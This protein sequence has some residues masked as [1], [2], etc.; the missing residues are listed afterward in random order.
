MSKK[1]KIIIAVIAAVLL[2]TIGGATA[3]LAQDEEPAP[4]ANCGNGFLARVAQILNVPEEDLINAFR[5]AREEVRQECQAR[6]EEHVERCW[7]RCQERCL[8]ALDKAVEN[9]IIT[10]DEA[11]QIKEWW[12]QR[13]EAVDKLGNY[14]FGARSALKWNK[15]WQNRCWRGNGP[16][17]VEPDED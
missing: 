2:L 1:M 6:Y 10:E 15:M 17:P 16:S 13:P 4:P 8:Q 3:V 14:C 5:Q 11:S 12:E 9:G 7:E